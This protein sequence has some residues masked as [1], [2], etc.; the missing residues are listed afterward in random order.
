MQ[1]EI[2]RDHKTVW[3][4]DPMGMCIGRFQVG[5]FGPMMDVHESAERQL[6]GHHCL[7]CARGDEA[8]WERFVSSMAEHHGVTVPNDMRP[9]H[10]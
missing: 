3:V 1:A 5:P 8:T 9:D 10:C 4:N 7:D 2:I 6:E